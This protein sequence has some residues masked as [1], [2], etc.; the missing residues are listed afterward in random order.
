MARNIAAG[1]FLKRVTNEHKAYV[2]KAEAERDD[3]QAEL[4]QVKVDAQ[5]ELYQVK[6]DA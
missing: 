5:A 4:Q 2:E 6:V 3:V 1:Q